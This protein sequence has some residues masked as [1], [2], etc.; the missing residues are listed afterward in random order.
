MYAVCTY[1]YS[2]LHGCNLNTAD[3]EAIQ[4]TPNLVTA[5]IPV[6]QINDKMLW[7]LYRWF[8]VF[9]VSLFLF[10]G[11][12]FLGTSIHCNNSTIF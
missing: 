3:A 6:I 9:G 2:W 11:K 8:F 10:K 7:L 12:A 1:F 4:Q 5:K